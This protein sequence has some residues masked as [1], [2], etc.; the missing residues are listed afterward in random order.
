MT[1]VS[2]TAAVLLDVADSVRFLPS[3]GSGG[4]ASFSYRAWDETSGSVGGKA[5]LSSGT[6]G[7]TA[8]SSGATG[9]VVAHVLAVDTPPT[10]NARK[11]D[12]DADRGRDDKFAG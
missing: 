10:L 6:G 11:P 2:S 8:F 12:A 3:G 1:G 4:K 5:N 7:Q 9:T